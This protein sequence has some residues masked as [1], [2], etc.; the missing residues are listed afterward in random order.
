MSDEQTYKCKLMKLKTVE[1]FPDWYADLQSWCN[2]WGILPYFDLP[3]MW[4]ESVEISPKPVRPKPPKP[5]TVRPETEFDHFE[6]EMDVLEYEES[7]KKYDRFQQKK[8]AIN[9][10]VMASAPKG[11]YNTLR[12]RRSIGS[13]VRYLRQS[14]QVDHPG[15]RREIDRRWLRLSCQDLREVD[16]KEWQDELVTC[17]HLLKSFGSTLLVGEKPIL[18]VL[19][20]ISDFDLHRG[21]CAQIY[22]ESLRDKKYSCESDFSYLPES[23]IKG[24]FGASRQSLC[25]RV[26]ILADGTEEMKPNLASL[27]TEIVHL[28]TEALDPED[29]RQLRLVCRQ[30]SRK[31]AG[32]PYLAL[33]RR[34][35]TNL[36]PASLSSLEAL[37]RHDAF[38]PGNRFAQLIDDVVIPEDHQ[39]LLIRSSQFYRLAMSAMAKIQATPTPVTLKI[40]E[41]SLGASLPSY[42]ITVGL[43]RLKKAGLER[44]CSS[45]RSM[46]LS[47]STRV[48]HGWKGWTTAYG[49]TIG[50]R[51]ARFSV[52]ESDEEQQGE[53]E[54]TE[55]DRV[56]LDRAI[57]ES[58]GSEIRGRYAENLPQVLSPD[59]YPGVAGLVACMPHL[60]TLD[61]HMYQT[62]QYESYSGTCRI[63]SYNRVFRALVRQNVVL[64]ELTHLI[65]RGVCIL[66]GVLP[67]FVARQPWLRRL[68]LH[69]VLLVN[70]GHGGQ[71]PDEAKAIVRQ[72]P[73]LKTLFLSNLACIGWSYRPN[74]RTVPQNLIPNND[75][76]MR[77]EWIDRGWGS[78]CMKDGHAVLTTREFSEKELEED[79]GCL[80]FVQRWIALGDKC[81][82]RND[83][84]RSI[85]QARVIYGTVY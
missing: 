46:A 83:F 58:K 2:S 38:S 65:L 79:S 12:G 63:P 1:D 72:A 6:N 4:G 80:D 76:V 55:Q 75:R 3:P 81:E 25:V 67:A 59:N 21:I 44:A 13:K 52:S 37:R 77:R 36:S 20:L 41:N 61:L 54:E 48:D 84:L 57:E 66:P 22:Y 45:I 51:N 31:A 56:L 68:E 26:G 7:L 18:D 40:F 34:Q 70:T 71:W 24:S 19:E 64:P 8:I 74:I 35:T 85:H 27:P 39:A 5:I 62:I 30:L 29:L 53:E 49:P 23:D 47:F 9:K 11:F 32:K 69:N 60:G 15:T 10:A 16:I 14:L 82:V 50:K 43:D 33:F 28:L 42:D 73:R 78:P 17:H